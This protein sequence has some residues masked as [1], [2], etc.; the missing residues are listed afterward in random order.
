MRYRDS[1]CDDW[2]LEKSQKLDHKGFHANLMS[3]VFIFWMMAAG[4]LE[5]GI[6]WERAFALFQWQKMGGRELKVE[7][8]YSPVFRGSPELEGR[9]T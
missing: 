7:A 3:S 9:R 2:R 4:H 5:R 1:G 6:N 8:K